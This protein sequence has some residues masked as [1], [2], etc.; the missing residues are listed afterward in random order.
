MNG[1]ISRRGGFSP[2]NLLI[3][4]Y[5]FKLLLP[6]DSQWDSTVMP[7]MPTPHQPFFVQWETPQICG[8]RLN[9]WKDKKIHLLCAPV[10]GSLKGNP[11]G[12]SD[13]GLNEARS[14]RIVS[15]VVS[16]CRRIFAT[17]P[18]GSS[19]GIKGGCLSNCGGQGR[20][21][22]WPSQ[23]TNLSIWLSPICLFFFLVGTKSSSDFFVYSKIPWL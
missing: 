12:Q 19:G 18:C 3:Y 14:R 23:H 10:A 2:L 1:R 21:R 8:S 13:R 22:Q 17:F 11:K 6:S 7:T 15:P 9:G 4:W 16:D 5:V 20:S